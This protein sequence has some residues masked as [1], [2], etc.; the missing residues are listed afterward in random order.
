MKLKNII[1]AAVIGMVAFQAAAADCEIAIGIAPISE[2]DNV[3]AGISR[4]LEAKLKTM[5]TNVGVAAA[6]FD[7][8]FFLTGRFDHAYSQEA[9]G[10]GG[11]VLVKTDLQLAICDGTNK[12]IY[13]TATFPIK[14]VGA[15]D[16]QAITR[17]LSSLNASNKEFVNFVEDGKAKI[18]EYFNKNYPT[19]ITKAKSALKARVYDEALYWALIIPECSKGYDEARALI[20]TII[21]DKT[22]YDGSMLLAQAQ[23][24]WAA[25]PTAAGAAAAYSY[26]AQID[27]ASSAYPAAKA[28]GSQIAATVKADYDFETKEKYRTEVALEKQR[29]SA[30]RDAAVAWAQNQPKTVYKTNWIIW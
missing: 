3:S 19:Y 21:T 2:G 15:T 10:V 14:G 18:V 11:R 20:N 27:P 29:I 7:C 12:K 4:K 26:L 17:G 13:A 9:S 5:L 30:A 6:D 25:D 28:L 24:E 23:G 8:Q 1:A 22:N 16:E